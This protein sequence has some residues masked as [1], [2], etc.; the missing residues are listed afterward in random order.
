[1]YKY[2]IPRGKG[3]FS[4]DFLSLFF[5][6]QTSPPLA[7]LSQSK[8]ILDMTSNLPSQQHFLGNPHLLGLCLK[9]LG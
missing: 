3:K 6:H 5:F 4:R 7:S 2:I 8:A 9:G 1:M